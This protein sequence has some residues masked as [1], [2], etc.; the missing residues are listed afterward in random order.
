MPLSVYLLALSLNQ[1][2]VML[3]AMF[4]L[5]GRFRQQITKNEEK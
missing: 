1:L 3:V 2:S 5:Y 4:S